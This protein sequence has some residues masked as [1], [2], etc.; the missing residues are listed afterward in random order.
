VSYRLG[1][2][3]PMKHLLQ[4]GLIY[5]HGGGMI[6]GDLE[7]QDENMREAAT[8]LGMPIASIDYRKAPEHPTRLRPRIATPVS[9]GYLNM[10]RIWV[11]IPATSD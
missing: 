6:M 7:S 4:A 10:P 2:I 1:F 8:E 9:A 11:W 5:I 3:A